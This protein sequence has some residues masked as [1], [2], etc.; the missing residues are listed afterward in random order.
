MPMIFDTPRCEICGELAKGTMESLP[1][2]ALFVFDKE[3]TAEYSGE[4]EIWWNDQTT[5][6]DAEGRI[7]LVCPNDHVWYSR[8]QER[9]E[10]ELPGYF[11]S[12]VPG[13]LAH[14]ED[15]GSLAPDAAV[16]R[17]GLCERYPTDE[18]ARE[19]LREMHQ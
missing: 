4:T 17:C 3:D 14:L 10:C 8:V 16:E 1:G 6:Y 11:C 13:I 2:V 7:A 9:C 15:D 18:A 12:G 19:H 5:R